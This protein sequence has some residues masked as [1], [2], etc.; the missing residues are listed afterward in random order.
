MSWF[1][2]QEKPLKFCMSHWEWVKP[3]HVGCCPKCG[4]AMLEDEDMR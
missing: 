2:K 1:N 4:S 3:N